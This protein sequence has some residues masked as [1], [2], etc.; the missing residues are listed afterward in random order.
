[1]RIPE[2]DL[3]RYVFYCFGGIAIVFGITLV[4]LVIDKILDKK[5]EGPK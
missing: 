5:K 3:I 1:M 2:A 4:L